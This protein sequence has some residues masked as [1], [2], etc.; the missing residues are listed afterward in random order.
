MSEKIFIN[1][2]YA[3]RKETDRDFVVCRLSCK[4]VEKLAQELREKAH[5]DGS[6]KMSVLLSQRTGEPYV[7]LDTWTP[8]AQQQGEQGMAQAREVLEPAGP[9]MA[10]EEKATGGDFGDFED[11]DLPF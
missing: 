6:I 7:E 11:S 1:E 5:D 8:S 2:L 10:Q 3:S 4:D 9:G